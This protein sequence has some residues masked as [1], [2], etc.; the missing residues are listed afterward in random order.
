MCNIHTGIDYVKNTTKTIRVMFLCKKNTCI[1]HLTLFII[2]M[3][4]QLYEQEY[5]VSEYGNDTNNSF[6]FFSI[7]NGY[8]Y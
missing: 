3:V 5:G 2:S 1:S 8:V 4:Y 7:K 6:Q